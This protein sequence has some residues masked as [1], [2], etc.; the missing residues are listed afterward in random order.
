M[1]LQQNQGKFSVGDCVKCMYGVGMVTEVRS[2][3]SIVVV[4]TNWVLANNKP[5]VFYLN[6]NCVE[7]VSSDGSSGDNKESG[8]SATASPAKKKRSCTVS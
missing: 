2:A 5:P 7:L 8:S 4:P 3:T 1:Y 6:P